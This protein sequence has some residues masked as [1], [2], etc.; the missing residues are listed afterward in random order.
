[1]AR[2]RKMVDAAHNLRS[3]RKKCFA[4]EDEIAVASRR[5]GEG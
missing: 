1:M 5:R 3:T 4:F 2:G